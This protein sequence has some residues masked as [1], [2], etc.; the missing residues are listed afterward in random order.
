MSEA[1][2]L[3]NIDTDRLIKFYKNDP[4]WGSTSRPFTANNFCEIHPKGLIPTGI[5]NVFRLA[6][7]T[8]YIFIIK[9]KDDHE[10]VPD[11]AS[12]VLSMIKS[13]VPNKGDWEKVF[14]LNDSGQSHDC[15][16]NH[17]NP[18]GELVVLLQNH[19]FILQTVDQGD[20]SASC[21][22]QYTITFQIK[23]GDDGDAYLGIID[24]L[25]ANTSDEGIN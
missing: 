13:G 11:N 12:Y 22:L 3:I 8:T 14:I 7:E 2:V 20:F 10:I 5:R 6:P 23:N 19:H 1:H 4:G 18:S 17:V 21:N 15:S 24:P 25:I 16:P 9:G